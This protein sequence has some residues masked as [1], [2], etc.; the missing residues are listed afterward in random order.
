M[1][2][3]LKKEL[4]L[5][6]KTT[7]RDENRTVA[8]VLVPLFVKNGQFHLLFIQRTDKVRD[9]KGQ[10]SFPGGSYEPGDSDL[11]ATAL[12]EAEEEIGLNPMDIE[13]IGQLDDM[14]T[15]GT[16]FV[17]SPYVGLIPYPYQFHVDHFETEEILQ[18]PLSE[19][20]DDSKCEE[21]HAVIDG[22][23]IPS[24]FYHCTGEK[25]VWGA[26]ARIVKQL[27]EIINRLN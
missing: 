22:E 1:I 27:A 19:F 17:I 13:I 15:A 3:A 23:T 6:K 2:A 10:I 12:R 5:R 14:T 18:I 16:R 26:T 8:A 21:G 4:F 25:V 9:H 24:Y 20:L 11:Q 7:I